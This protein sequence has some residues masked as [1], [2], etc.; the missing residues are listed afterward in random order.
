MIEV[1]EGIRKRN[2]VELESKLKIQET[3]KVRLE[4]KLKRYPFLMLLWRMG[5]CY[6]NP[7]KLEE[8]E[9]EIKK[10]ERKEEKRIKKLLIDMDKKLEVWRREGY[11]VEELEKEGD[12][13]NEILKL[14]K[15]LND[16]KDKYCER[17]MTLTNW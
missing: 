7:Q 2:E 17:K 1:F 8:L 16:T 14:T 12:K 9:R 5:S 15:L 6:G 11:K 13:L 4:S 3:N 10:E